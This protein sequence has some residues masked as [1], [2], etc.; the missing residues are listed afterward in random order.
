MHDAGLRDGLDP[1]T[2]ATRARPARR[3]E[4]GRALAW[5]TTAVSL[6]L[7]ASAIVISLLAGHESNIEWYPFALV[8]AVPVLGLLI[9]LRSDATRLGWLLLA[10]GLA[11]GVAGLQ[12]SIP[13]RAEYFGFGRILVPWGNAAWSV[14]FLGLIVLLPLLFPSGHPPTRRWRP[15]LVVALAVL[16]TWVFQGLFSPQH[17]LVC[18]DRL[19]P[20][21][22]EWEQARPE[23]SYSCATEADA[24]EQWRECVIEIPNYVGVSWMP[25]AD[26]D[27]VADILV[28]PL[29]ALSVFSLAIRFRRA[30]RIERQQ[31]KYLLLG[32]GLLVSWAMAGE[33]FLRLMDHSALAEI[34]HD[35]IGAVTFGSVPLAIFL[36]ISRY[37]L[38]EIDRLISRTLSYALVVAALGLVFTAGVV[39]LPSLFDLG[40]SPLVVAGSTLAVAALFNPI[41]SHMR[42]A[43]DRRFNRSRYDAERVIDEFAGSL[44]D[45]LDPDGL[46]EGWVQVVTETMQPTQ[47]AIWLRTP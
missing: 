20:Q 40:D 46:V 31:I 35:L 45:R 29:A 19:S 43:V 12:A 34:V 21:C 36:A 6:L 42:K 9:V 4:V 11:G 41:R 3:L 18:S 16:G 44:R 14:L 17:S 23:L 28:L 38:Y 39:V 37:R 1:I 10:I 30:G 13:A 5:A 22:A 25:K 24:G 32:V 27:S 7:A 15:V 8:V 2:H 26:E 47:A 33:P